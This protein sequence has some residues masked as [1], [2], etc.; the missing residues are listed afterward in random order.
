MLK[1]LLGSAKGH[2]HH[3]KNGETFPLSE[4]RPFT[5][6]ELEMGVDPAI[7]GQALETYHR[8]TAEPQVTERPQPSVEVLSLVEARQAARLVKDWAQSDQLRQKIADLGW[9]VKDTPDGP[10][11]ENL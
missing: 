7:W 11:I 10:V 3:Y 6:P 1:R 9:Q 5:I 2:V 8:L 4:R